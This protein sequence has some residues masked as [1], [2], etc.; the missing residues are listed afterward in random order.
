[1]A[2]QGVLWLEKRHRSTFIS[3]FLTY[4]ATFQ[5]KGYPIDLTR[6]SERVPEKFLESIEN[7]YIFLQ[8]FDSLYENINVVE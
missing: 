8:N 4:F 6:L 5:I 7:F 1:M 3:V 2:E